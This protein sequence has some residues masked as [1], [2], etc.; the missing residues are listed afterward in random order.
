MKKRL[1]LV[2]ATVTLVVGSSYFL[3]GKLIQKNYYETVAKLNNPS[4]IKV[5]LLDYKR[6]VFHSN[7]NLE[8]TIPGATPGQTLTLAV[9]QKITHGPIIAVRTPDGIRIKFVASEI[10]TTLEREFAK[11][12]EE[13]IGTQEPFKIVTLV[14]FSDQA[15]TWFNVAGANQAASDLKVSWEPALGLLQHDLNFSSFN[16]SVKL[17]KLS[18][19][20]SNSELSLNHLEF[21]I[22]QNDKDNSKTYTQVLSAKQ[23]SFNKNGS[24]QVILNDASIKLQLNEV[25]AST[26]GISL[27]ANIE[28]SQILQQKFTND[29]AKLEITNLP[30]DIL[31]SSAILASLSTREALDFMQ[32]LSMVSSSN[33]SLELPKH[34]TEALLSYVSFEL[35]KTSFLG[36][37]DPRPDTVVLNDISA[38]IN[39]LIQ[40]ALR[41]KLFLDQGT[42]YALNYAATMAQKDLGTTPPELLT[43]APAANQNEA[44]NATTVKKG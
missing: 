44:F 4:K 12:L 43:P 24:D 20:N 34:F 15:T 26:L 8:V 28:E 16:G 30:I 19:A 11:K 18:I 33:L 14:N 22:D 23:L 3:T 39:S 21:K 27:V 2:L 13:A 6:G 25:K 17:P 10:N 29:T 36:K 37:S 38:S 7:A 9:Q 42:F 35:Y 31:P 32:R 5:N 40:G 1:I 41:Q